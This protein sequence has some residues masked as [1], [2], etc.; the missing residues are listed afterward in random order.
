MSWRVFLPTTVTSGRYSSFDK[1]SPDN[2]NCCACISAATINPINNQQ[3]FLIILYLF[4]RESG[5]EQIQVVSK[6]GKRFTQKEKRPA[7][8]TFVEFLT[9]VI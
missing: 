7:M 2:L 1:V 6:S 3:N 5:T 4:R 9:K 8:Q